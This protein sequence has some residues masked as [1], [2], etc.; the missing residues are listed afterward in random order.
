MEFSQLNGIWLLFL[1][2]RWSMVSAW[3]DLFKRPFDRSRRDFVS[4][5]ARHE[6]KKTERAYEMLSREASTGIT[7]LV[8]VKSPDN[9]GRRTPDY[10]GQT[11][12]YHVPTR[13]YSSPRPPPQRPQMAWSPEESYATP[14]EY[15][16][17]SPLGMNRI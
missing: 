6:I 14:R 2:G 13:S 5:D 1:L 7:P 3:I 10:F 8:S 16:D 17:R 4:V 12:H 9:N 11:A 15:G